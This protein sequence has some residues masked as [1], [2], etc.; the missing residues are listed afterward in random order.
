MKIKLLVISILT[1]TIGLAQ[2]NINNTS[3]S[4][5]IGINMISS[6]SIPVSPL[7]V[8]GGST[9]SQQGWRQGITLSQHAV[10][11]FSNANVPGN[12][13]FFMGAPSGG[14]IGNSY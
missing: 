9:F 12:S 11:A 5:N 14:P 2:N 13:T 3:A 1:T 6:G 7:H 8:V 10:L 4:G